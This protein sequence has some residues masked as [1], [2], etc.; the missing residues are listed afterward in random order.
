MV[1]F[2]L[3]GDRISS[4]LGLREGQEVKARLVLEPEQLSRDS[5]PSFPRLRELGS[6]SLP[7]LIAG[8]LEV[9]KADRNFS[10]LVGLLRSR[11]GC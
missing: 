10:V 1:R 9:A 11:G 4:G 7:S 3:A 5:I 8:D 6:S 2:C